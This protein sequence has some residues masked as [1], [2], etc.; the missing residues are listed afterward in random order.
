MKGGFFHDFKQGLFIAHE[1]PSHDK[2]V[3]HTDESILFRGMHKE[4]LNE[5]FLPSYLKTKRQMAREAITP[6]ASARSPAARA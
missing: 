2:R 4:S 1:M 5:R 3:I 6:A